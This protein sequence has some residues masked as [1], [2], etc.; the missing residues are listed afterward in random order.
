MWQLKLHS[1][2]FYT[3]TRVEQLSKSIINNKSHISHCQRKK[4]LISKE[5]N[6]RMNCGAGLESQRPV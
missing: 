1:P 2:I 6:A 5:K 3:Y 4:L